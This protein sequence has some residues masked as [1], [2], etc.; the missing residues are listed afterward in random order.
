MHRNYRRSYRVKK[1]KSILKNKF[2]WIG[3]FILITIIGFFYFFFLSDF[4][5]IKEIIINNNGEKVSAEDIQPTIEKEIKEKILFF[6]TKSIFSV[7]LNK[8][9][10]TILNEFPQ[11]AELEI[12][13]KFPQTLILSVK[14]RKRVGI[15]CEKNLIEEKINCFF[16][17]KEGVIF[18]EFS[19]EN[20]MLRIQKEKPTE[21]LK[22]GQKIIE[23]EIIDAILKTENYLKEDLKIPLESVII[24]SQE[25]IN[26]KTSEGWE[27]YI[28]PQNDLTWQLTK[29]KAV[30][31]E[32]ISEEKRKNLEYIEL[33]FKDRVFPKFKKD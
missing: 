5:Q 10:N 21:N 9:K 32:E 1:K 2:F 13:R 29:L 26:L 15:F 17:D 24:V 30:L 25:R 11:I 4:F 27:I 19:G 12:K 23:N 6:E 16:L 18:E 33:R 3:I 22:L 14:E 8:I 7:N 28:N 20:Q 31:K